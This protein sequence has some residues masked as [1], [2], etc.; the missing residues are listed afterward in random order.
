MQNSTVIDLE[1]E[2]LTMI[3]VSSENP[4]SLNS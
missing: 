1:N 2:D 4:N 3:T